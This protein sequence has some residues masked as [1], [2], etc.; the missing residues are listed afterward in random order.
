MRICER[1]FFSEDSGDL[2]TTNDVFVSGDHGSEVPKNSHGLPKRLRNE[3]EKY[4]A[5]K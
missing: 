4:L 3:V 5:G 1:R 2:Q